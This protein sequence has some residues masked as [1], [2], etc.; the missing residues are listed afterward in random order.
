M[1]AGD[2]ASSKKKRWIHCLTV[3]VPV[4]DPSVLSETAEKHFCQSD[5]SEVALTLP[6]ISK[7]K[8]R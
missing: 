4:T 3:G 2:L 5:V 6:T 8:F 7:F 1:M